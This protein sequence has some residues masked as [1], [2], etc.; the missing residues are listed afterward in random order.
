MEATAP[1]RPAKWPLP[2]KGKE[3]RFYFAGTDLASLERQYAFYLKAYG[4]PIATRTGDADGEAS[5]QFDYADTDDT[6]MPANLP[7]RVIEAFN[8][9]LPALEAEYARIWANSRQAA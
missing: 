8:Y 9:L 7:P 4:L 3:D 2:K 6:P 1:T 5:W